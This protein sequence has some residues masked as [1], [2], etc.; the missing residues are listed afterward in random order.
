M[1]W[2]A[3]GAGRLRVDI[4][5]GGPGTAV[6]LVHGG[7]G[8]RSHWH[9]LAPLLALDR[10]V[11]RFDQRGYGESETPPDADRS[12]AAMASDLLAVVSATGLRSPVVVG[13]SYGGAVTA[14]AVARAPDRF[15]GAVFLDAVGDIRG[16]SASDVTD[17][18]AGAAPDRF[19]ATS[20]AWFERILEDARPET[21]QHV[22]ST[23]GLT[24]RETYVSSMESLF[25]YD[26]T[27]VRRFG[28]P[29]LL[30]T[31]RGLDG[32][33]AM[34][35]SLPELP[36]VYVEETSHWPHLDRPEQIADILRRFLADVDRRRG[37]A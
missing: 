18:R 11:V 10:A 28:G 6:L 23:L 15:S 16:L 22:L 17:W 35:A 20:R 30:I 21:R 34:R 26:P 14:E 9:A 7:G 27:V 12:L 36:N 33:L 4:E 8:D 2:I 24:P 3:G 37:P 29:K 1:D 32:P 5:G 13:H 19:R 31:V 25:A